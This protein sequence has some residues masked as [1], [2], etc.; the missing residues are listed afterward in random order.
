MR[1]PCNQA[2]TRFAN[3]VYILALFLFAL[4]PSCHAESKPKIITLVLS[5]GTRVLYESPP[6][7]LAHLSK[8]LVQGWLEINVC[9]IRAYYGRFPLR[10]FTLVLRAVDGSEEISTTLVN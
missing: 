7:A 1:I 8:K 4:Q 6:K 3:Y 9:A 10:E 2:N 5:D